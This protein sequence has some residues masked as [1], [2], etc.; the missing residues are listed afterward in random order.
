MTHMG[1]DYYWC[2]TCNWGRAKWTI[3]HEPKDCPY[4]PTR[5]TETAA[6]DADG[7]GLLMMDLV[8]SGFCAIAFS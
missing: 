6:E 3:R 7:S 4:K 2:G 8:E 1:K 5:A